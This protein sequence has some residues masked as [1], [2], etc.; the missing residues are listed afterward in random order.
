MTTVVGTPVSKSVV[1]M[2]SREVAELTGKRHTDVKRDIEVMM[3]QLNE[4]VSK[5]AYTYLDSMNRTQTEYLLDRDHVECLL[6]GYS[7]VIRMKVI[8]RLRELE[9]KNQIPQTLPEALR[10]AADLAEEKQ[11][12]ENQLSIAAPKAEFVDRY[13]QATGSM[14]FRNVCKLLKARETDFRLFLIE[15]RIMYRL[16]GGLTPYQQHIDLE[17]FEVKTGTNT[18]NNHAFTQARFTPKGVKWIGGLWAEYLA[19]KGH[20]A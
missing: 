10:L 14:V 7:A 8:R 11:Q 1:T 2:S 17:R 6:A 15:N 4:D 13:V 9:D 5:F 18:V 20:A 3:A 16:A 19:K 12:L